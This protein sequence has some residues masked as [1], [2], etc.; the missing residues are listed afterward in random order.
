MQKWLVLLGF[1]V[2]GTTPGMTEPRDDAM[3]AMLRCTGIGETQAR[4]ACYDSAVMR[5]RS[6]LAAPVAAPPSAY[7]PATPVVRATVPPPA[8]PP[9][10]AR[11]SG[12]VGL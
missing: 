4:L 8:P 3:A 7:V 9:R 6:A 5:V 2:A 12:L 1:I 10:A 11:K